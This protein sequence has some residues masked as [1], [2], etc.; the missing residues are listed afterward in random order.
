MSTE[1]YKLLKTTQN[2]WWKSDYKREHRKL[3]MVKNYINLFDENRAT[4]AST[5]NFKWLETT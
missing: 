5:E 3:Q 4:S 1:S 2:F